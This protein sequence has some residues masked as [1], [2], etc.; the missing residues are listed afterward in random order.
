MKEIKYD[1]EFIIKREV[2]GHSDYK[3][4][5]VFDYISVCKLIILKEVS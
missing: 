4:K 3:A 2:E 5:I 1:E